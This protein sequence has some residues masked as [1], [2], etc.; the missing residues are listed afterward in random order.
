[1]I[2]VK[3]ISGL[4]VPNWFPNRKV[5]CNFFSGRSVIYKIIFPIYQ[6]ALLKSLASLWSASPGSVLDVGTGNGLVAAFIK[7]YFPVNRVASIDVVDRL[8][9]DG[10]IDFSVYDGKK[11]PFPDSQFDS[12]VLVNVLHH[13][14]VSDRKNLMAEIVR[15]CR[16][17]GTVLIK[18]HVEKNVVDRLRLHMMDAIGNIPFS[19]MVWAQYLSLEDWRSLLCDVSESVDVLESVVY[20]S[21]WYALL[22]PNRLEVTFRLFKQE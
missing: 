3:I 19:G 2:T 14:P 15:V 7:K 10:D 5:V 6:D 16:V 18:D 12:V 13:V 1:M 4:S 22:F 11:I 21:W 20:R 9:S 8:I 17:G